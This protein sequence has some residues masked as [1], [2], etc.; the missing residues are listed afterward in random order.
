[1]GA[2]SHYVTEQLDEGPIIEQD[3]IRI[4]HRDTRDD[5]VQKGRDLNGSCCRALCVGISKTVS[6]YTVTRLL[7]SGSIP[8]VR[9]VSRFAPIDRR[10]NC[11]PI[12]ELIC[13]SPA[14]RSGRAENLVRQPAAFASRSSVSRYHSAVPTGRRLGQGSKSGDSWFAAVGHHAGRE[15]PVVSREVNGC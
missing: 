10:C 14:F 11:L 7:F 3:I 1:M 15:D 6:S 2:T 5:L 9:C 12:K 8:S 4:N 13:I